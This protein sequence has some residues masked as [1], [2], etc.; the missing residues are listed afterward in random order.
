MKATQR[1]VAVE[2]TEHVTH[3]PVYNIG[4]NL[5]LSLGLRTYDIIQT[6]LIWL[7]ILLIMVPL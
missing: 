2:S 4:L 3:T 7:C 6:G 1:C 5:E